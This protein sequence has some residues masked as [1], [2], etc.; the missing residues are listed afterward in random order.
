[1]NKE[2]YERVLVAKVIGDLLSEGKEP[3]GI[4]EYFY[5]L[6]KPEDQE[7]E[8]FVWFQLGGDALSW[9][10]NLSW[11][12]FKVLEVSIK[13]PGYCPFSVT[14]ETLSSDEEYQK[15]FNCEWKDFLS[16]IINKHRETWEPRV[17]SKMT[18]GMKDI[19]YMI[20]EKYGKDILGTSNSF[21]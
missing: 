17:K 20:N 7:N 13:Q 18:R 2:F 12:C 21:T 15:W 19:I 1:M 6:Q 4:N 3:R 9:E 8:A 10:E 14:E 16:S 5:Y 11:I